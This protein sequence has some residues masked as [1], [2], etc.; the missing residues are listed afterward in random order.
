MKKP[1]MLMILDGFGTRSEVCGNAVKKAKTENL[2]KLF[3]TYPHTTIG[4][5]GMDV[6]LPSGQMGNS[7]VG[8][9]NMGSGRI[10]YQELTKIT[11][12]IDDGAFDLNTALNQAMT[13]AND[14][15]SS[16]HLMG[17]LS[18]G[19]VHSHIDHLIALI[20]LAKMR[21]VNSVYVHA[22]LDGRDTPPRSAQAYIDK[23][24]V[25]MKAVCLGKIATISGRYYGMDRDNR[26]Q[27]VQLSYDAMTIGT[28]EKAAS[29]SEA[30]EN[31][32]ARGENDEFVLPTVLVDPAICISEQDAIIMFNFRPDR[33]R[34]IT[35]CFVDPHF[36]GFKRA[37]VYDNLCYVCLTQY[38]LSMPNVSVAFPPQSL[39][40]TLGEYLSSLDLR[41]LRIAETEKYAHVTFFFN[42][43]VEKPYPGEDRILVPSPKVATYD[44]QP[45]MSAYEVTEQVISAIK[46]NIYDVIV[47][48]FANPDMVGHTGILSAAVKA[49]ETIDVCVQMVVD[50][51]L[52]EGGQLILT[53]D[54]G[55]A[56]KMLDEHCEPFTAHTL[57]PV[58]FMIIGGPPLTLRTHGI[59]A[60]VAP[61]LLA[62]MNLDAPK[63]M[64]GKCLIE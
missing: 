17:L 59:L 63:E 44:L 39:D 34:E 36:E 32:Y 4:A 8:H 35:R 46:T 23:L 42:G 27:R 33:A 60:D 29:A 61:T 64:T 13:F 3:A 55:N 5:S 50:A 53:A 18:D 10:V 22:F 41:Q 12:E 38:D 14:H 7:E 51:V 19:G 9:L 45:E 43:G 40:N 21:Q 1:T 26:W 54:H 11:K 37:K 56:E 62:L 31:A 15:K 24:E 58:P 28:G 16:L 20:D 52:A 25:H 49:I 30:L 47:L 6:G 2:D 57:S 48:N